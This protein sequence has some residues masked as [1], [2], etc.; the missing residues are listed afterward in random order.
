[1]CTG[2]AFDN[3]DRFVETKSGKDTL[4]DTVGIIYQNEDFNT[5]RQSETPN[6]SA[7]A[8]EEP[9]TS[10]KRRRR[11]MEVTE[12][13]DRPYMKKPKMTDDLQ[14]SVREI[15]ETLPGNLQLYQ[16]ID[17]VWMLSHAYQIPNLPMW[18]RYNC[19]ISNNDNNPKQ[20]VSYLTPINLLQLLRKKLFFQYI[21]L[22]L[23]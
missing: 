8:S 12:V 9:E 14:I 19:L 13:E 7:S 15:E 4:H 2:V 23:K 21:K 3:F 5:P 1:M 6:L 18:V 20:V 17:V 10:R 11:T 16:E 22:F